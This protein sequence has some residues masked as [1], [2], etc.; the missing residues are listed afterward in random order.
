MKYF[1]HEKNK[2]QKI[3]KFYLR[4][5]TSISDIFMAHIL[6]YDITIW[7]ASRTLVLISPFDFNNGVFKKGY[8]LTN[9]VSPSIIILWIKQSMKERNKSDVQK[10]H[11]W[12]KEA[13]Y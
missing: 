13:V 2:V 5:C 10:K 7:I 12:S 9:V 3:F 4:S 1:F 6:Y 11:I 8:S